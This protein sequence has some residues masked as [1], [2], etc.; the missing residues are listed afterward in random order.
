MN[1][2]HNWRYLCPEA[3]SH[4]MKEFNIRAGVDLQK[5]LEIE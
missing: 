4:D 3:E 5:G 2:S 1:T